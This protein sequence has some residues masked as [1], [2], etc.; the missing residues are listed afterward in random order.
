D[1]AGDF[2]QL[3]E[4]EDAV[5]C[6]A[7]LARAREAPAADERGDRKRMVWRA[8]RA[9]PHERT[10]G[11]EH[12]SHRLDRHH[13]EHLFL[14]ERWEDSGEP[15][16]EH[17]LPAARRAEEEQGVPAGGGDLQ[18]AL[19]R[20]LPHH[21]DQVEA[22]LTTRGERARVA[23][24]GGAYASGGVGGVV[25]CHPDAAGGA[26]VVPAAVARLPQ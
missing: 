17:R 21:V 11:V 6:E 23:T 1:R 13:L 5:V 19:R 2:L 7:D 25:G 4:E 3:I 20:V 8:K 24:P 12:T 22:I 9:L 10:S 26:Q 14:A 16:R 18:R 15:A